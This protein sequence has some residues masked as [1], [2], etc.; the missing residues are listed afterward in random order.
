MSRDLYNW[1]ARYCKEIE[2]PMA[3]RIRA[4]IV[5]DKRKQEKKSNE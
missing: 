1:Y 5:E 3:A 2:T 4:L